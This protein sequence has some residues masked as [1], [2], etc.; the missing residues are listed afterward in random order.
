[1]TTQATPKPLSQ[2]AKGR[3][4]STSTPVWVERAPNVFAAE[5]GVYDATIDSDS[6][7]GECWRW[8]LVNVA[9]DFG[10]QVDAAHGY[11]VGDADGAKR[12]A[13]ELAASFGRLV[14]ALR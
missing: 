1:V 9:E 10:Q 11:Y 2:Q 6:D 8:S 7:A 5:L 3:I 12:R 14:E 4:M 13:E